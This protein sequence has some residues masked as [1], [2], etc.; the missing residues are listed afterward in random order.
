MCGVTAG[1][2]FAIVAML[3]GIL[4]AENLTVCPAG[5]GGCTYRRRAGCRRGIARHQ[6]IEPRVALQ[7]APTLW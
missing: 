5:N 1:C 6:G 7:R 2:C 4:P 3:D